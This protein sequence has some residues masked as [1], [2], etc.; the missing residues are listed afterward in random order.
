MKVLTVAANANEIFAQK[1]CPQMVG[2][3]FGATGNLSSIQLTDKFGTCV[4]LSEDTFKAMAQSNYFGVA[5]ANNDIFW[6][7]VADG[8]IMDYETTLSVTAGAGASGLEVFYFWGRVSKTGVVYQSFDQQVVANGNQIFKGFSKLVIASMG[9]TDLLDYVGRD[10]A[11]ACKTTVDELVALGLLYFD[12]DAN[13]VV[14]NNT[15]QVVSQINFSPV[16][17]RTCAVQLMSIAGDTT[18]QGMT[19]KLVNVAMKDQAAQQVV[20]KALGK[21]N[22][23]KAFTNQLKTR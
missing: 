3:K 11:P 21:V 18:I 7:Q 19:G 12:N 17:A 5:D 23:N 15:D 10:G 4:N 13:Y 14:I 8:Y 20:N 2:I 9:A 1:Y 6:L 16:A 22:P